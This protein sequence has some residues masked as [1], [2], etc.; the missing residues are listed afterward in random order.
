MSMMIP[1]PLHSIL[2][3]IAQHQQTADDLEVLR[4]S[5]HQEGKLL[6]WVSQDGK[7]N[8]NIGEIVGGQVH[9]G[10]CTTLSDEQ[11]Q[12]IAQAIREQLAPPPPLAMG[13]SAL[14]VGVTNYSHHGLQNLEAPARNAEA[15][16]QRLESSFSPFQVERLPGVQDKADNELET[17]KTSKSQVTLQQLKEAL[18]QYFNPKGATYNDTVLFYFSGHGLYDELTGRSYLATSDTNQEYGNWGYDLTYLFDL[19]RRSPVKRQIIWLDC[20]HSGGLIIIK[21]ATPGGQSGYSR[22]FMAASQEIE[23]ANELT[24]GSCS[25]LTDSLLQ[26]LN[27]ERVPGEWINTLSLCAFVNQYLKN[28][29]KTP[30]LFLNVGKPIDLTY[31]KAG[32]T[33]LEGLN[34]L[35]VDVC[36]YRALNAFDFTPEDVKVFFGRTALVDEL[37]AQIDEHNFLAV[38]GPS[39]SGKSSV[40]RAGLLYE[41]K[42]G[43]RHS[44]TENWQILP[45]VRP[46][47]SPL[48][49]LAGGF[50][51]EAYRTKKS[52]EAMLSGL[53]SDFKTRGATALVDLIKRDYEQPVVLVIDQFEE[54]FTLCRGIHEKEKEEKEKERKEFL[55]CLFEAVDALAGQLRLVITLRADFL[56]KCLEQSYSNLAGRI[57]DCRVDITPL[58]DSE[59]NEVI[60]RPAATVGLQVAPYLQGRLKEHVREAPGSL[61]LLEY[62]LTELWRDWHVHSTSGDADVG[63]QLT[64]EGYDR[65]GGVAGALDKQANAVYESFAESTFKQGLV[66]RIFLELVQPGEE[67]EDTRRQVLKRELIS[68]IHPESMVDEVLGKLVEARLVVADEVLT[69]NE[70]NVVVIDLAHESTIRHWQQ[71]RYWLNKQ[72]QDLPLIRQLRAEAAKWQINKQ[73]PKYLLTGAQLDT[74]LECLEKYQELGYLSKATQNF[75]QV[76]YET[77]IAEETEKERHLLEALYM[78]AELQLNQH[79]QLESLLSFVKAGQRLQYIL[80]TKPAIKPEN[81]LKIIDGLQKALLERV[82]EKNRLESHRSRVTNVVYSPD[83]LTLASVS[84]DGTIKLWSVNDGRLLITLTTLE[85][86]DTFICCIAYSPDGASLASA[87]R[88][89]TVNLW[90]VRTGNL[91][92]TLE[93]HG[94]DAVNAVV[95]SPDGTTLASAGSDSTIKLWDARTGNFLATLEGHAHPVNSVERGIS[96][97]AY[98]PDGTTLASAGGDHTVR[99][100]DVEDIRLTSTTL[101]GHS[102]RVNTVIYSPDGAILVSV[103]NDDTM[104]LWRVS[105]GYLLTTLEGHTKKICDVAYSPDGTTLA[106]A[107]D[108]KAVKLWRVSDGNLLNTFKGHTSDVN[109]ISY[110]PDGETLASA[111]RDGTIKLWNVSS[112]FV[113]GSPFDSNNGRL[114]ATLKGHN[115][116]VYDIAYSP[117]GTTLAS[118]G[119]DHTVRLWCCTKDTRLLSTLTG[120]N[121][122]VSSIAYS[123]DGKNLASGGY[124]KTVKLWDVGEGR[125]LSTFA[126]HSSNVE[127]IAFSPSGKVLA[128]GSRD[129]TVKFWNIEDRCLLSTEDFGCEIDT[130]IFSPDRT[131]VAFASR[132]EGSVTLLNIKDNCLLAILEDYN[133]IGGHSLAF[134]PDGVTL[135]FVTHANV[136]NLWDVKNDRFLSSLE[137]HLDAV[138]SLAFSPD[139]FTLASGSY[140]KTIKLWNVKEGTLLSTLKSHNEL[141]WAVTYS[142][143]GATLASASDDHTVK[144]WDTKDGRLLSTLDGHSSLVRALAY[145]P[146]GATLASGSSDQTIKIW[147]VSQAVNPDLDSIVT[148][149]RNWLADYLT[150]NPNVN[151]Q[152]RKLLDI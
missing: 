45:I 85:E 86:H 5:L 12:A 32:S 120:H 91:V 69:E 33:S 67:T 6:Q 48:R 7:F 81:S 8:V 84:H 26:G 122:W 77:W 62:A 89:G 15:I 55:D 76:S 104:K 71:L 10:D 139:G 60:T 44:G 96:N 131:T 30:P 110:S 138:L 75:V 52:G 21:D 133:S 114:I 80:R 40:V 100:W 142:P 13:R 29:R 94:D 149:T 11:I 46:G 127:T 14:V 111:S 28:I 24:S 59:L 128:S 18:A 151:P 90:N 99:L 121:S 137:G 58:T 70:L 82:R 34:D 54:I 27:P 108:D 35:Q 42:Q 57:K 117:D 64:F 74:A 16:A 1:E 63:N 145:S 4:R 36:P 23:S 129:K 109:A 119:L 132:E 106:S 25:V 95:Y 31:I 146:D 79:Q 61:P 115:D 65:I 92:A 130:I 83:G 147:K 72:R 93:G 98:S 20:Y 9:I 143:D 2:E 3:R 126:E 47:E 41:L 68:E 135:A 101:E 112:S 107:S 50:V 39:G 38:L 56:G 148:Y 124:D 37:L 19:L 116:S 150:H 97:I 103:S 73:N 43:K 134:S 49:H 22:C 51:P 144:L 53:L 66:Q 78:T 102:E 140:D 88:D 113:K 125:L 87:N 152:D 141:V 123:P 105:D 136:L 118:A 17:G